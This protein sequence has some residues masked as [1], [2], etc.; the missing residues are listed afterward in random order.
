MITKLR[1]YID[2]KLL[3]MIRKRTAAG[4]FV[5]KRRIKNLQV[6][7]DVRVQRDR[8]HKRPHAYDRSDG[9]ERVVEYVEVAVGRDQQERSGDKNNGRQWYPDKVFR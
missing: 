4:V 6:D 5:E 3:P 2:A 7:P 9:P 8:V 1:Y